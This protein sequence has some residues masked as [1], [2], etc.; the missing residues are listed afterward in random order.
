MTFDR[1][2]GISIWDTIAGLD[3]MGHD[4]HRG[5][6]LGYYA[7]AHRR[8]I[9][10]RAAKSIRKRRGL[11]PEALSPTSTRRSKARMS[12]GEN[13]HDH[14]ARAD[15]RAPGGDHRSGRARATRPRLY[16]H[17]EPTRWLPAPT[18]NYVR[19]DNEA[20]QLAYGECCVVEPKDKNLLQQVS[21]A[22][23]MAIKDAIGGFFYA[24]RQA[25]QPPNS[26]T[27]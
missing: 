2:S 11:G 22:D 13:R 18:D 15:H 25:L 27:S 19:T 26:P 10:R 23:Q 12:D 16:A 17:G 7:S 9:F 24:A 1:G 14:A 3:R 6:M 4:P 21:L 20:A 5:P 8:C